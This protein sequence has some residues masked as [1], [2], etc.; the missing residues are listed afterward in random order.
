MTESEILHHALSWLSPRYSPVQI[1][2]VLAEYLDDD[3]GTIFDRHGI[4]D[5]GPDLRRLAKRWRKA[6]E[7]KEGGK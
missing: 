6:G 4:E 3:Q 2:E 7:T 5:A 1:V